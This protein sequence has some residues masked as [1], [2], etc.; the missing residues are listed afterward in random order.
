VLTVGSVRSRHCRV[1]TPRT[2][3][4]RHAIRRHARDRGGRGDG[5]ALRPW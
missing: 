2:A 3:R 5:S 1:L 4:D